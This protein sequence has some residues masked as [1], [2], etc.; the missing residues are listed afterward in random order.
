MEEEPRFREI[1]EDV[2]AKQRAILWPDALRAGKSVD[3][4]L[5][6][7][8]PNAKPI[9][10]AGLVVFGFSFWILG[11]SI[12]AIGWAKDEGLACLVMSLVGSAAALISIRLLRNAFLRQSKSS[13]DMKDI[14]E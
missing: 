3:E 13:E 9:Q 6:K 2:E 1:R 8:D 4:F 14:Q 5:W 10:R 12:I 11:V 7:G